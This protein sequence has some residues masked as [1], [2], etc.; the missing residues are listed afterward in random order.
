MKN[1]W[2]LNLLRLGGE[3]W[4]NNIVPLLGNP[5][6]GSIANSLHLSEINSSDLPFVVTLCW[7]YKKE[8]SKIGCF[9]VVETLFVYYYA[10]N[11]KRPHVTALKLLWFE[12]LWTYWQFVGDVPEKVVWHNPSLTV[13]MRKK[14]EKFFSPKHIYM[15]NPF[16]Y[17]SNLCSLAMSD[18]L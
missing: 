15:G 11:L 17:S 14:R 10:R 9:S 16:L 2:N 4:C 12:K 18:L 1:E 8:R 3:E 13:I 7:R 5:L 6:C